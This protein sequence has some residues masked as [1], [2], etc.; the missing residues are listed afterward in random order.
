MEVEKTTM[1]TVR[2]RWFGIVVLLLALLLV[3]CGAEEVTDEPVQAEATEVIEEEVVEEE[4]EVEEAEEEVA[5]EDEEMAEEAEGELTDLAVSFGGVCICHAPIPVGIEKGIYE[6]HGLSISFLRVDSGFEAHAA[7]LTGD[8]QVADS[9]VAVAA[10]AAQQGVEATAVLMANGD[11]TGT[12]QTDKYFALVAS[13]ESGIEELADLEGKTV[14][15]LEGAIGHQWLYYA[16]LDNG[17]DPEEDITIVNVRPPDLPSALQSGSVDAIASWEP[18]A[19]QALDAMENAVLVYR[20]GGHIDYLFQRWMSRE[21]IEE[22]PEVVKAFVAAFAES[23]QYVRQHPEESVEILAT[24]FEGLD[25][26]VIA[27]PLSYL[28][29]DPRVSELTFENAQQGLEF[30][31][32]TGALRGDYDIRSHFDLTFLEEVMEEHPEYFEDLPPIPE[33]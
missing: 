1:T 13:E 8:A 22:N 31:Q 20:G 30:A 24:T 3:A 25:R 10:Q 17:L 7:V 21:F 12:I 18:L 4:A 33:T 26:D 5:A 23:A 6:K 15:L 11:P 19:L 2:P 14:G 32:Q 29:F 16:L 9:V 27:E 28:T